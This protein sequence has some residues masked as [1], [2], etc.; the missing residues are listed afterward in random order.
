MNNNDLHTNLKTGENAQDKERL[1]AQKDLDAIRSIINAKAL[2]LE[3][4]ERELQ[5]REFVSEVITEAIYDRQEHDSSVSAALTPIIDKSIEKSIDQHPEKFIGYL[6]PLVGNLVRKFATSFFRD[7]IE[8]TNELIENSVTMKSIVWRYRAWRSGV[9]FSKYVASQVYAYQIQQVLLIHKDTGILLN[10]VSLNAD[11]DENSDL[12]SSMLTAISDFINDSFAKNSNLRNSS[13]L[14]QE[15]KSETYSLAEIKTHEFTLYVK[16]GPHALLVAAVTGNISPFAKEKLQSTLENI[17]AFYLPKLKFFEGETSVFEATTTNLTDCLLS[18]QRTEKK[19]KKPWLAILLFTIIFCALAYYAFIKW[20]T[21][22]LVQKLE[23]LPNSYGIV[24]N[25]IKVNG[26]KDIDLMVLRDPSA[27]SIDE[28]LSIGKF[29]NKKE[30]LSITEVPYYSLATGPI[31]ARILALVSNYSESIA[32]DSTSHVKYTPSTNIISGQLSPTQSALLRAR[33]FEVAG[34]KQISPVIDISEL[35][36]LS[37]SLT[38]GAISKHA[39]AL[40]S[41]EISQTHIEFVVSSAEIQ[42]SQVSKLLHIINNYSQVKTFAKELSLSP[43]LLILGASDSSGS[44]QKNQALSIARA[45][46][47]AN[48]LIELGLS[49]DEVMASSLNII[50]DVPA[51]S[52]VRRAIIHVILTAQ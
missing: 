23:S 20:Q 48:A 14:N 27:V 21:S 12:V 26:A 33:L 29:G 7:F 40:L 32:S 4:K 2:L 34:I 41:G 10:S 25:R 47:T 28:W 24:V 6:Y 37:N 36:T 3:Q 51:N 9:T 44:K 13:P 31:K 49:R 30:W 45:D 42:D 39:L 38:Q 35:K 11:S 1:Q 16:Q 18:E 5:A 52:H 19:A 46:N 15:P 22:H 43:S 17:H 50:E 8:K